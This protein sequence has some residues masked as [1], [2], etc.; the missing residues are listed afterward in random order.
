M[1]VPV[2]GAAEALRHRLAPALPG[3]V[4]V[5]FRHRVPPCRSR[6][7]APGR[8]WLPARAPRPYCTRMFLAR[9]TSRHFAFSAA[10]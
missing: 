1:R 6:H 9:I 4:L 10:K 3:L 5:L 8:D 7:N 2:A